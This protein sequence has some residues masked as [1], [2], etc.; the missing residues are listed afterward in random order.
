M[1]QQVLVSDVSG[2]EIAQDDALRIRVLGYPDPDSDTELDASRAEIES[3][4][5]DSGR[6]IGKRGRKRA[7]Q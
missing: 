7:E 2:N 1:K 6:V 5:G 4:F 3:L